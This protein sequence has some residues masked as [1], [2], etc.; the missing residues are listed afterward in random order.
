LEGEERILQPGEF[1][2][3]S[4]GLTHRFYN[5]GQERIRFSVRI[6]PGSAGFEKALYL[7]YGL[8]RD[9]LAKEDGLSKDFSHTALFLKRSDTRVPGVLN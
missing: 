4:P 3:V 2:S 1:V 6:E 8:T 7:L 9:G 5:P